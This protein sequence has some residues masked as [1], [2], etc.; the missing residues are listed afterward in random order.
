MR[1]ISGRLR[2]AEARGPKPHQDLVIIKTIVEPSEN[3]PREVGVHSRTTIRRREV[4]RELWTDPLP[5]EAPTDIDSEA[6]VRAQRQAERTGEFAPSGADGRDAVT[7]TADVTA[8]AC[9]P[10]P[11]ETGDRE[12]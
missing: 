11:S 2:A 12:I 7:A 1:R 8:P 6:V 9:A 4:I 10:D 5:A 3:G